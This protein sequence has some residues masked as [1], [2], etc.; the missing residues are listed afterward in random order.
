MT[1]E[2]VPRRSW[3]DRNWKWFVPTG[4]LVIVLAGAGFAFT[5]MMLVSKAMKSS[6]AYGEAFARARHDCELQE[7][8]GAPIDDGWFMSGTV[9][10]SGPSGNAD[11]AIPLKGSRANATLYATAIKT[12]GEWEFKTLEA[13]V[14]GDPGRIDLL[15]EGRARCP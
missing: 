4:C 9:N 11:I 2:G 13:A 10:V 1:V 5:M 8:L 15:D 12:A 14:E 7:K 3:W 6:G